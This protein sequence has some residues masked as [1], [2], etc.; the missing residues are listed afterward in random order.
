M[1]KSTTPATPIALIS[2]AS[3]FRRI[4][5]I[6][7][8]LGATLG[9][10]TLG[11]GALHTKA[12]HP[13]LM[14]LAGLAGCPVGGATAE[15]VER[16]RRAAVASDRGEVP[17][18]VRPALGFTLDQTTLRDVLSWASA[19]NL[20]CNETREGT[21]LKCTGVPADALARPSSQGKLAEIAFGFTEAGTLV[22]VTTL[23]SHLDRQDASRVATHAK[24]QIENELGA[25][26][27]KAGS[28]DTV[29]TTATLSYR[30]KDY[31]ADMTSTEV[32][33]SGFVV[34]EMYTSVL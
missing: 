15:Q 6:G 5:N 16:V 31:A 14:S 28:F 11:I 1:L 2:S 12:G 19:K 10:L 23:Y 22:S 18:P 25:P 21:L 7:L 26:A 17:A 8:G 33:G 29:G 13:L 34:R 27:K 30:F 20:E 4:R 3:P 9:L 32:P 24:R